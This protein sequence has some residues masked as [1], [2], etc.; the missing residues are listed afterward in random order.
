MSFFTLPWQTTALWGTEWRSHQLYV[1]IYPL[2]AP[3][4]V[5]SPWKQKSTL[6]HLSHWFSSDPSCSDCVL[7][8]VHILAHVFMLSCLAWVT[9]SGKGQD[10]EQHWGCR[11]DPILSI[12][13]LLALPG[14]L[15][16]QD[17]IKQL[18]R[19]FSFGLLMPPWLPVLKVVGVACVF[20][21]RVLYLSLSP[22]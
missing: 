6:I 4:Q 1:T 19:W 8:G 15:G 12:S 17:L 13:L 9:F 2:A 20:M 16:A 7:P 14:P 21:C 22:L 11:E 10:A 18:N 3:P 5:Q